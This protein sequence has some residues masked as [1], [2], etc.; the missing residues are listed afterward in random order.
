MGGATLS[1]TLAVGMIQANHF[2]Y[3]AQARIDE[4]ALQ[5]KED[6]SDPG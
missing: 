2:F 1:T 4:V 3:A 6:A 5:T